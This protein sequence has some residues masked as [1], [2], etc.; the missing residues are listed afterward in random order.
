VIYFD[1][2]Y[3]IKCYLNERG[4]AEVRQ[5]AERA[6][7]I[8]C[9]LHGRLEFWTAVKRNVRENLIT[10]TEANATFQRLLE[11]EAAGVWHWIS[12]DPD[13][14]E[15][16]CR[17]VAGASTSVFLRAADA[18]HLACAETHGFDEFYTHDRHLLA[19]ASIFGINA[20][21]VID[22]GPRS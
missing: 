18:L 5:L 15:L 11:D 9:C 12:V 20:M 1:T 16:A 6:D 22:R 13:M 17:K 19:A 14:I 3:I 10:P 21:D 8:G 7:G 2:S 4:S